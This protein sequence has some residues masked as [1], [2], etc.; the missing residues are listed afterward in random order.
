[1][2]IHENSFVSEDEFTPELK[3]GEL[4]EIAGG[5]DARTRTV[6][7]LKDDEAI[8]PKQ[9]KA[10][11]TPVLDTANVVI[12]YRLKQ[13][14]YRA[15]WRY[16]LARLKDKW[17]FSDKKRAAKAQRRKD[18]AERRSTRVKKSGPVSSERSLQREENHSK[19]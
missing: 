18:L 7:E 2:T 5:Y 1:M 10:A 17:A 6:S 19:E 15:R 9:L 4:N 14:R 16:R 12:A 11:Q 3:E 8:S 13:S